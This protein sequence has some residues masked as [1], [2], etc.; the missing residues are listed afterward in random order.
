M[1]LIISD[2]RNDHADAVEAEARRALD[3][4]LRLN[5]NEVG[6]HDVRLVLQQSGSCI[7]V[8]D[9]RFEAEAVTGVFVHHP[10][11]RL[12]PNVAGG[13]SITRQLMVAGWRQALDWFQHT[14][15]HSLWMNAPAACVVADSVPLQLNAARRRGLRVPETCFTNDLGE[16]KFFAR[17]AG[18]LVVKPGRLTGVDLAGHRIL[19][20]F[21]DI[22]AVEE[23][24]LRASPCLFQHYIEKQYELRV[25][26]VRDKVLACKIDSQASPMTRTDW[27]NYDLK[28]TPHFAIELEDGLA[29]ACVHI[30]RDLGLA[31]GA[32]DLIVTPSGDPVFLECNSHPH[33][34]WIQRLT[35][36]SITET[37]VSALAEAGTTE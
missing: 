4:V 12:H 13:D 20:N 19:T 36:L 18:R 22:D 34:L 27:R 28:Q 33:W 15:K 1:L 24:V 37:I 5:F 6:E 7:C 10:H 14:L 9:E 8:Q 2:A 11:V 16:L 25:Y 32:I 26:V 35:G 30:V 29:A 3:G 21:V 23:Q 31:L 17:R